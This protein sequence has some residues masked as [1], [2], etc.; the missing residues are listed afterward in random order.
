MFNLART[1]SLRP[2]FDKIQ[3]VSE[4]V[5]WVVLIQK[6][7]VC[8]SCCFVIDPKHT[9]TLHGQREKAVWV[10]W[11]P[12]L[13]PF[14]RFLSTLAFF[15]WIFLTKMIRILFLVQIA[16]GYFHVKTKFLF[17][18]TTIFEVSMRHF[19]FALLFRRV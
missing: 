13:S 2:L 17:L 14:A 8:L 9:R 6:Q 19:F 3:S 15:A 10:S 1:E 12:H 18:C 5:C 7:S 11:N 4:C 16:S